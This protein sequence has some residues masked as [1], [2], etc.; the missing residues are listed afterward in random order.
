MSFI[1]EFKTFIQ[2][3]NVVDLAVGVIMGGAF[4]K[5][6]TSLVSDVLMPPIGYVIGGIKFTDLVI[7]L[8]KI[9]IPDPLKDGALL[10]KEPVEVKIGSFL[11][12]TF[13]FLIIAICVFLL[14]K[15][16]NSMKR[17]EPAPPPPALLPT[18]TEKLLMEIRDILRSK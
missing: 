15:A 18:E 14:V 13:D 4:G 17:A 3:G 8:P 1:S 10:V 5:I 6:V 7:T 11:Q 9:K 2:R 12:S 16:I